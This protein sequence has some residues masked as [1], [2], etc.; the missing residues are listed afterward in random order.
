[1]AQMMMN[2]QNQP[3]AT[4]P[5]GTGAGF[6]SQCGTGLTAGAKFCAQCGTKVPGS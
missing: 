2:Q 1:M 3:R 4:Q 6:C 5:T